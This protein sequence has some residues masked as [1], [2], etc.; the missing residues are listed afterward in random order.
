M[1]ETLIAAAER[2]ASRDA[3]HDRR[4]RRML[5]GAGLFVLLALGGAALSMLWGGREAF[6]T[7]GI[8]FIAGSTWDAIGQQFGAWV[9][10]Y[11]T[12]VTAAIAMIIAVPV[13]FGIALF[14]TEVAPNWLRTPIGTAIASATTS[15]GRPASE[16]AANSPIA[17]TTIAAT[18]NPSTQPRAAL[19]ESLHT[20]SL[21]EPGVGEAGEPQ[22]YGCKLAAGTLTGVSQRTTA[23]IVSKPLTSRNRRRKR[24]A[25]TGSGALMWGSFRRACGRGCASW[26]TKPTQQ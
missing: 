1:Q 21:S 15:H 23:A 26:R 19:S 25:T 17:S 7:F 13:S 11:G 8:D 5:A 9:P 3:R 24:S 10:I 12:L 22:A 18:I 16:R 2:R 14:L 20:S 4:F 6:A